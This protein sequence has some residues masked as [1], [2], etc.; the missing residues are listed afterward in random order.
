MR[1]VQLVPTIGPGSGVAGVAWNL[2][3]EFRAMGI[4]TETFTYATALRGEPPHR[5]PDSRIGYAFGV[6]RRNLWF[7]TV[8]TRR[9][10]EF[11]AERPDAVSICHN[12]LM[13]GDIYVNHGIVAAAMRAR[14]RYV[15]RMLRNPTHL[16]T[17]LRDL[18]RYRSRTHRAIVA[19]SETEV[20]TLRRT[21]GRIAPPVTVIPN[22]VDLDRFHPPTAEERAAA[23]SEFQLG[24]NDRVALF[25]GHEF[26]RK[27]LD[28]VIEALV[29]AP[30][31]LLM[32]DGGNRFMIADARKQAEGLGVAERVLFVGPRRDVP[33]L[34]AASDFF[35][36][37]SHYESSGLVYLE[38]LACGL[39]VIATAVGVVP[40][41]V[42]DDINGFVVAPDPAQIG[43]RMERLAA[44]DLTVWRRHAR[45][46][47]E[48]HTWRRAAERYAALASSLAT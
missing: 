7:F 16:F 11:L 39:P 23:R 8:G 47:A 38:A 34:M 9:A 13:A 1:I 22:G 3:R 28:L 32:V 27:G 40:E 14:G 42:S 25:V 29:H 2:D 26:G 10:K 35:V 5:I 21:F 12:D 33:R 18:Y 4:E 17:Y 24:E 37:P 46:R 45:E 19:L 44:A 41:V 20:T 36:M 30:S 43:D 15:W 6:T 31:M 48:A